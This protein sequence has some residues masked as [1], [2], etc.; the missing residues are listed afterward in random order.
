MKKKMRKKLVVCLVSALFMFGMVNIVPA[1]VLDFEGIWSGTNYTSLNS[2]DANYGGFT[3]D[4]DWYLMYGDMYPGTGYRNGT[5]DDYSIFNA[6]ASVVSISDVD[7]DFNGAYLTSAWN[8][9]MNVT[10]YGYDDSLLV[11]EETIVTSWDDPQFYTFDF[12]SIDELVFDS[13]GGTNAGLGGSGEHFAM[14]SFTFNET[15]P[16]PE[17]STMLLLGSGL[18]GLVLYRRKKA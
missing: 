1:A 7:F 16:I 18:L 13:W 3:W 6:F 17:P 4:S 5:L 9:D 11:Y 12:L 10:V 15:A 14:D 8:T 2:V